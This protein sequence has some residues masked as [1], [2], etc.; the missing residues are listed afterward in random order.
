MLVSLTGLQIPACQVYHDLGPK[1]NVLVPLFPQ[2]V[3][4]P[5]VIAAM[6]HFCSHA[7]VQAPGTYFISLV[8]A[9]SRHLGA[10]VGDPEA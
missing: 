6:L 7:S 8:L 10:T 3:P 5:S 9:A 4:A 2:P 1:V